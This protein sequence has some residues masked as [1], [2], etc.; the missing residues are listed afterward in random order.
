MAATDRDL[1]PVV[2]YARASADKARD[3]HTVRDQ[4]AVNDR[5]AARL[6]CTIVARFADNDKSAMKEGIIRDS[7]EEM[8]R[9]IRAGRLSDGTAVMG[10]IVVADDRLI[11]RTG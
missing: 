9:V 2:D 3:E 11:R 10:C 1:I 8:L 5:T 6:G 7:F 4:Q